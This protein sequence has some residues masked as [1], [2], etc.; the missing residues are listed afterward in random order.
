MT[1]KEKEVEKIRSE[2]E[3]L[4]KQSTSDQEAH[5]AAQKHYQAVSSGLSSNADGEDAT[6][7]D[8]L[9]GKTWGQ[10]HTLYQLRLVHGCCV[11]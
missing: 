1:N 6:L 3:K 7:N 10:L 2:L 9:M 8:Q 11:S 5:S 4:E